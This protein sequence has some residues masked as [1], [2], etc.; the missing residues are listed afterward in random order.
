[1]PTSLSNN[2]K[3]LL[4]SA[5]GVQL[6]DKEDLNFCS[7]ESAVSGAPQ[8]LHVPGRFGE[9]FGFLLSCI[10]SGDNDNDYC[11][12]NSCRH[13]DGCGDEWDFSSLVNDTMAPELQ[14]VRN[15]WRDVL[16]TV[17][18]SEMG[19]YVRY[20]RD[21][22]NECN[23]FGEDSFQCYKTRA[24]GILPGSAHDPRP[25]IDYTE[26]NL[27]LKLKAHQKSQYIQD[28]NGGGVELKDQR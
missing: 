1:M 10:I 23:E 2:T 20:C 3:I 24:T 27:E 15:A 4:F 14:G 8:T 9:K 21:L 13:D 16:Y 17:V 25:Y 12:T 11:C 26:I 19:D 6:C 22:D 28:W 7:H 5:R 18:N